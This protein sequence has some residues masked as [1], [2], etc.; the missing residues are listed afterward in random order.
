MFAPALVEGQLRQD[1]TVDDDLEAKASLGTLQTRME[2][3]Q[4]VF[5]APEEHLKLDCV[6]LRVNRLGYKVPAGSEEP[7][8][9]L[10]LHELAIGDGLKAAIAFVRCPRAKL[11]SAE[12]L[13]MRTTRAL[14]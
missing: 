6:A 11:P 3:I 13:A 10:T 14:L 1:A 8:T 7:A 2:H 5:G 12:D 4:A 9:Q